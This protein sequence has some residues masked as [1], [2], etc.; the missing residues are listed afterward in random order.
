MRRLTI[1]VVILMASLVADS[2]TL[3][4][5]QPLIREG[6]LASQMLDGMDHFLLQE[7]AAS[8]E[9]RGS[10]WKRDFSSPQ[11]YGK[12]VA[13]NRERFRRIIGLIDKRIP[14]D[15]PVSVA[16]IS[17]R[18]WIAAGS[19][20]KVYTVRWPVLERVDGEG[21]L[22]KPDQESV[23]R[24][25]ALP[26]ADWTPE[27][28]AGM[29][30]GVAP[31][32]QF[33]RRLAENGCEVLI[34]VLLDRQ[35]AGL[36]SPEVVRRPTNQTRRE[37]I[38][39]MA[40][41]MGRH[42]IG[43]EVQKVLAAVDWFSQAKPSK[44][45]GV[46]G[47]GEGGLEALYSAAAD[48]RI[49]A[50]MVSGYFQ[51]RE[52]IWEEPVYR[53]VWGLLA[54]FGDAELASL[55]APRAL[56][57]EASRG[58]EVAGPPPVTGARE[59]DAAPGRLISPPLAE[60]RKEFERAKSIVGK[61]GAGDK[62]SLVVSSGGRGEPGSVPALGEFLKALGL[63]SSLK[64]IGAVLVDGRKDFQPAARQRRQFR[65]LLDFT[66]TAIRRSEFVRKDFWS[67]ADTSS[68]ETWNK[69]KQPYRR[70][71]WEEVLG[72]LRPPS[73]PLVAHT[74]LLYD[75]PAWAGYEVMLP[76]FRDVFA[77]GVLLVPKDLKPGERRPVVVCQ[78]G[79][80]RRPQDVIQPDSLRA[81]TTYKKFAAL[82]ADRGFVVYAPQN[83]YIFEER[84]RYIQRKANP[85]KLSLF[86]FMLS[87]HERTL[88]WL[89]Q[90][91][92]VDGTRIGFYGLSYGGKTAVR[93]PPL[94]DRYALSICSGD[95]NEYTGKM[96]S[97]YRPDSFMFTYEHEMYEFNLGNTF[98]YSDMANLMAPRPFMVER[99]HRDGVGM[100]EW[101]A[102]EYAKVRRFYTF[103]GIPDRTDIEF[104]K[105]VHEI[106]AIGTFRFLRERLN[107]PER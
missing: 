17:E 23:A 90:L 67:K 29:A 48:T 45:V 66:Q 2:Q 86:S 13:G 19:G 56:V 52:D 12:S 26:D 36:I 21:L 69:T 107:W 53:N 46:I 105:G 94:L 102:Y 4:G 80:G 31:E 14:F 97:I 54:E 89:T 35:P 91:P 88:A 30:P 99:G 50:A 81:E 98:D 49:G 51:T 18:G 11:A 16:P 70:Y 9:R 8:V 5:T 75:Q 43:Y 60:T 44:P 104:F 20:Y 33:A 39:R 10:R 37:F 61:L 95:F 100:D 47:Y 74:R 55:V 78:H 3:P 6:D 101:V 71:L 25:I 34:P 65:Q 15:A 22:L 82:L 7:L 79:R 85:L 87:Q 42:V 38:Y 77:Y 32:A 76:L 41:Q 40:F 58:P 73:E 68:I 27:M 72:K 28:L 24:V 106:N 103:L 59:G 62:L 93:V 84:Y 1:A 83:P 64:P 92:F 57:I 96:A 63:R